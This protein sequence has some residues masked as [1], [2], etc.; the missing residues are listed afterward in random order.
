MGA[1]SNIK[2]HGITYWRDGTLFWGVSAIYLLLAL[3]KNTVG[4]DII[5]YQSVYESIAYKEWFQY[6]YIYFEKGYSLISQIFSKAG[7][8]F[9]LFQAL[10]YGVS[11]IGL[12]MF[13]KDRSKDYSLSLLVFVCYQFLVFNISGLRQMLATGLCMISYVLLKKD[14]ARWTI[15]ALI[16]VLAAFFIHQ[17][18]GIFVFVVALSF[19]RGRLHHIPIMAGLLV[20]APFIRPY[21]LN[22]VYIYFGRD[23]SQS[24]I[25]LGGAFLLL[26]GITFGFCA[27]IYI[28]YYRDGYM[29]ELQI[30]YATILLFSLVLYIVLSGSTILRA[31]AYTQTFLLLAIPEIVY[32]FDKKGQ[33]VVKGCFSIALVYIFY[34][35]TLATNQLNLL[36]YLFYWQ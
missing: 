2:I 20:V 17:S 24:G 5:G 36:P 31:S 15:S 32:A 29:D 12:Y 34:A 3:K 1:L 18:A 21:I 30:E 27:I 6:D 26:V 23:Y 4:I 35:E 25:T 16:L 7:C 22:V 11:C 19:I 14:G 13:L 33:V 8:S 10:I 9:Q 28:R